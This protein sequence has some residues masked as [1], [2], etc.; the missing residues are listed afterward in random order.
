M[1]A[2]GGKRRKG[3][4]RRWDIINANQRNILRNIQTALVDGAQNAEFQGK[5]KIGTSSDYAQLN[6]AAPT[7]LA[8][9]T[10]AARFESRLGAD[11]DKARGLLV[12]F[13]DTTN[14]NSILFH[15]MSGPG[16]Y[17]NSRV[18]IKADDLLGG[19]PPCSP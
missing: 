3:E 8:T 14:A 10:Y 4:T 16:P 15:A 6:V 13:P 19:C 5:V 17:T 11:S 7:N 9:P 2:Y 18:V 12:N 1:D